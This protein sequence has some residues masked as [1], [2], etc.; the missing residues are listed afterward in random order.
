[1][2]CHLRKSSINI[3]FFFPQ[4]PWQAVSH[5]AFKVSLLAGRQS[6]QSKCYHLDLE[7]CAL[8]ISHARG[9]FHLGKLTSW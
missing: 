4:S 6:S 7:P 1:M 5:S 3:A 8:T 2:D 9:V